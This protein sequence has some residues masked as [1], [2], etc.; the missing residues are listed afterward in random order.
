MTIE[1][2]SARVRKMQTWDCQWYNDC[3]EGIAEQP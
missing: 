1:T 2:Q 3:H